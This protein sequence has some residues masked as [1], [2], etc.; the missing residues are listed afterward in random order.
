MPMPTLSILSLASGQ[1]FSD[2]FQV[3]LSK[4]TAMASPLY[5]MQCLPL[6]SCGHAIAELPPCL[7]PLGLAV[8][9]SESSPTVPI[10]SAHL[11]P[12]V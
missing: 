10:L 6:L 5:Y 3:V 12:Y 11:P 8:A 1:L 9:N 7:T 4:Q 2:M